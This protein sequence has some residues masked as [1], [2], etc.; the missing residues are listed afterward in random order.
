MSEQ[1]RTGGVQKLKEKLRGK[2]GTG[3]V[4]KF[5]TEPTGDLLGNLEY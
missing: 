5:N 3:F 4:T 2:L 1:Q